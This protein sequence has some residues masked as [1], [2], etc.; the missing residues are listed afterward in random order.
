MN[1]ALTTAWAVLMPL[2]QQAPDPEDVKPGW[3]GFGVFLLL[4]VAVVLLA[5]SFRK[6]VKK[7]TFPVSD[8]KPA[9]REQ[10]PADGAITRPT[11]SE[12]K[13]DRSG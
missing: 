10:R 13:P 6:Q 9:E 12:D 4:V 5:F 3:L 11:D 2:A 8:D 1:A 7:V